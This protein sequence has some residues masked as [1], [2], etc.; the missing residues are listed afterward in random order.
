M[1]DLLDEMCS[2]LLGVTTELYINKIESISEKR[3]ELIISSL[4]SD[5]TIKI[6]KAI[7]IFN[8]IK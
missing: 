8:L 6:E 5:D 7:R 4:L 2:E 1:Y 3:A